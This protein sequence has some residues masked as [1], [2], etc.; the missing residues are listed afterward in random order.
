MLPVVILC[1]GL[2]TRLRSVVADCPKVLAPVA[3]EPF[4]GYLLHHLRR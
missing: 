4:L 3:G 1:G 2:G